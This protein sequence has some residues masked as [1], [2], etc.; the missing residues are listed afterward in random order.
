MTTDMHFWSYL[1]QFFLEWKIF[2]TKF[3]EKLETNTHYL[4]SNFFQKSCHLWDN[5]KKYCGAGQA[6]D[7]NTTHCMPDT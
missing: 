2:Q 3:V 6:T 4:I 5:G 1:V 7:G